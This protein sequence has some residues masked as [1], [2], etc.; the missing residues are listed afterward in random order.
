M[1]LYGKRV[2]GGGGRCALTLRPRWL[3]ARHTS[4]ARRG[5]SKAGGCAAGLLVRLDG[6]RML[7]VVALMAGPLVGARPNAQ[8][9]PPALATQRL[10]FSMDQQENTQDGQV[11]TFEEMV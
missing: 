9:T 4:T 2:Q 8:V 6:S 1:Y 5:A 11:H 7:V 10:P 3:E